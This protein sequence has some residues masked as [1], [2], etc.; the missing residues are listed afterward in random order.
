MSGAV[1]ERAAELVARLAR[2]GREAEAYEKRGR[3][4]RL[5]RG[6]DGEVASTSIE[7]GWAV[8]CGD[9]RR[10]FF[11]SGSGELPLDGIWPTPTAHP[12]WLPERR[13]QPAWTAP[14]GLDATLASESEARALL[15]AVAH[16]LGR[17]APGARL[18]A[19][20]FEEGS[21][22][23]ATASSRGVATRVASRV[24]TLRLEVERNGV[25]VTAEASA[26][27]GRE[28]RPAALAGR[29]ADR[30]HALEG[31][32]PPGP[33]PTLLAAPLAARLVEALAP[34]LVGR[35]AASAAGP[36]GG[37]GARL[38]AEQVELVDDGALATGLLSAPVDGEGV[39]CGPVRLIE[40][41]RFARPLVA[42]WEAERP[43]EAR[44]CSRRA[45]YRDLP[46]R[47]P[48]HLYLEPDAG[49]PVADLLTGSGSGSYLLDAEGGVRV[50]PASGRFAVAVSGFAMAGGRAVGGLGRRRLV[51]DLR[52]WLV[53]LR[54]RGRDLGF[55][56][57][58]GMFGAPTLLI[59]GLELAG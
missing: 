1:G 7:A 9:L 11:A 54:A 3:S 36:A 23:A 21:S 15:D 37:I 55:V 49:N 56:A 34:W 12:L 19:A 58:D 59:D 16:E 39:P 28:A 33:G 44:G 32:E 13:A 27:E 8:R 4:R 22:E 31:S 50:D 14:A 48:T 43:Q 46:R 38:G 18:V 26:R 53:G 52:A 35:E 20:R 25:R 29:I 42:W 5:E 45:S 30:L 57:G 17:E 24:A 10:S 41:G 6:P 51:G 47:A 40:A 2:G